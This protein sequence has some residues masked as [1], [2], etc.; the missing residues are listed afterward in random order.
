MEYKQVSRGRTKGTNYVSQGEDDK[1]GIDTDEVM[2]TLYKIDI[3]E[4][5]VPA[6]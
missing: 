3:I 2:F 6:E 1:D 5:D 4:L